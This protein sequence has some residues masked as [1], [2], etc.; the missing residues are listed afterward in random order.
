MR[1][2]HAKIIIM[3]RSALF[4][5]L[6]ALIVNSLYANL[7][8]II[9][10]PS[11]QYLA[12]AQE[13]NEVLQ[14]RYIFVGGWGNEAARREKFSVLSAVAVD[15]SSGNVYVVDKYNNR[16]QKFASNGTLISKWGGYGIGEERLNAPSGIAVDP[17]S[18][19]VYVVDTYNGHIQKFTSDGKFIAMWGEHGR[20]GERLNAPSGIAVDPSSGNVYV[21]DRYNAE[22]KKFTSNGT[23]ITKWGSYGK[24]D[25]QLN[26]PSGISADASGNIYVADTGNNRIQKFSSNGTFITKWGSYGK[27]DGQLKFPSS[28]SL[29]DSGNVL[30]ADT[31]NNRIQKFSKDG[32]FIT[33]WG[34]YGD[35][36]GQ[37]NAPSGIAVDPSE[38]MIVADAHNGRIQKFS[39]D[40]TFIT[41]WGSPDLPAGP[42]NLDQVKLPF[43]V[44]VDKFEN[45][46]VTDVG[47]NRVRKFSSNGTF[48]T[49]W[50][51]YGD[52]D[53]QFNAPSGIAVDP[54]GNIYVADTGNNRIQKFSSNGTF[55]TK[56]GSYGDADGQFNAPSGIAVDPSENV[57]VLDTYDNRIQ[58]F[59]K[60]G[61]FITKWGSY[62]DADWQFNAP[63]GISADASGTVY[64][65]DTGNNRIKIFTN[66]G[67]FIAKFGTFGVDNGHIKF[68]SG[69]SIDTF[70]NL[71]VADTG[72]SRIQKFTGN[73]TFITKWAT[74]GR[75][76]GQ[77]KYPFGV[78]AGSSWN[79]TVTDTHNNRIQL[80]TNSS[81]AIQLVDP[82]LKVE[83]VVDQG[84]GAP[85]TMTFLG[86]DDILV[87]EKDKGT[88]RRVVN[89][90][91]LK[92][93][94]LDVNVEDKL[95]GCLCGIATATVENNN[96]TGENSSPLTYVFLY[97]TVSQSEDPAYA[98]GNYLIR[99]EFRDDKLVNPK[100]LFYLSGSFGERH[101]G[102]QIYVGPD[103]YLYIPGGDGDGNNTKARNVKDGPD[104]DGTSGML[105]MT[106]DGKPVRNSSI[107][108]GDSYPHNL[109]FAYG[110]RNSYGIDFDPVTGKLWDTENGPEY[111]DEINL[112]EQGFNSGWK[113][114]HGL[115]SLKEG[116]NAADLET[117]GGKGKYSDP[118][119]VWQQPAGPTALKFLDS[120]KLGKQYEND[121]FVADFNYGNIYH[122]NLDKNRTGLALEG[123]LADR[124]ANSPE[125]A[126]AV[127]FAEGIGGI[128]D[129]EVGP[130]GLLYVLSLAQGKMYR[131]VPAAITET[132]SAAQN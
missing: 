80:F 39:K 77:L 35:A 106:L 131:I 128:T 44:A 10:N 57:Y 28:I 52:A 121:L 15:P 33:K 17:S 11:E 96:S 13:E 9:P 78:A 14:E 75:N 64:V 19:N 60:D 32:T 105:R 66:N 41:K 30:V 21:V 43:S 115:A 7:A 59:S 42:R 86:P 91:L 84:L 127:V 74:Y 76:E 70:G 56:W 65:A 47:D 6:V 51:S 132:T 116:F 109:Y 20:S 45:M 93:P 119:F 2:E 99:Y 22:I 50:G 103:G 16:V 12:F 31:Y 104:M 79:V 71:Y 69:I 97:F 102:G 58:K 18:G 111:G 82:R 107:I 129:M 124:V 61:T 5:F 53:G 29:D 3:I 34:S 88:V 122:F 95:K 98:S 117:F 55:I 48:I 72:N 54:F 85:T 4:S 62:G 25:G 123:P 81:G 90:A 24:N 112:V 26:A 113:R 27:N 40:G 36:D 100:T 130:D 67:T 118:E 92:E 87:V 110:I 89:G 83:T 23:F 37:F 49:K 108:F 63:F 46:F 8:I 126:K 68:P 1:F 114:V 101:N 120:D 38:N 94:L 73:G 125:E